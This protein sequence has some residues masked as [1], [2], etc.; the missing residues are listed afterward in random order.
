[1]KLILLFPLIIYYTIITMSQ[2]F[3]VPGSFPTYSPSFPF[4]TGNYAVGTK[5]FQTED[6]NRFDILHSSKKRTL[7]GQI[8][9]PTELEKGATDSYIDQRIIKYMK[10]IRYYDISNDMLDRL[11]SLLTNSI[12]N[13]PL[14]QAKIPLVLF[15]HGL[16]SP[17]E[18]HTILYED[19]ASHGY[20]VLALD[21]P[22]GGFS[23]TR[24]GNILS[25]AMDTISSFEENEIHQRMNEWSLDLLWVVSELS[26]PESALFGLHNGRLDFKKIVAGGH[27]LGGNIAL[28]LNNYIP[29][30]KGAFNMDGGSFQNISDKGLSVNSLFLRSYPIYSDDEL[31]S[32]G[33]TRESW[34]E[35]GEFIDSIFTDVYTRSSAVVTSVKI[36]GTGHFSYSDAPFL[37]PTLI[38]GFGGTLLNKFTT[39]Q[40]THCYV[41][42]LLLETF[43]KKG[44][45]ES[46]T[47]P[48]YVTEVTFMRNGTD[49]PL[50]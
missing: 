14:I 40:I 10:E 33:R 12:L 6:L 36:K 43:G 38:S 19:L 30:I 49:P 44:A 24:E 13:A 7:V 26:K 3:L 23:I 25:V 4:P 20:A 2:H 32:R 18:L 48:D 50:N 41:Q 8:W 16:G 45:T 34:N 17:K 21:H 5:K 39:K 46:C 22:Y 1:M 9:Y 29:Q 15:I 47:Q 37:I 31:N 27:S 11:E 42:S 28:G 35:M